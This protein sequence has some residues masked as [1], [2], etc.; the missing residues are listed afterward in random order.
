MKRTFVLALFVL[1]PAACESNR[2]PTA[3]TERM[4]AA[5]ALTDRYAQSRLARWEVRGHAAGTDCTVLF[6]ETSILMEDS[7]VEALH[8]GAGAYDV[9]KG[10]VQQFSRDRSFR[11]VAYK[12]TSNRIW[13]YGEVDAAEARMLGRCR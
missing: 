7:M 8:Y 13:T 11:G 6:V 1:I 12:D 10:G 2:R 4:L 5:N 3:D 9:Y